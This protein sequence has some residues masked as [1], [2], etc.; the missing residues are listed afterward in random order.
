MDGIIPNLVKYILF[1]VNLAIF[2]LG[3]TVF[4]VGVW[5]FLDKPSFLV[6]FHEVD[7]GFIELYAT[8][9]YIIIVVSLLLIIVAF[10]GCCGSIKENRCMLGTY[11]VFILAA[12]ILVAVAVVFN[13]SRDL[14]TSL[15]TPL[16]DALKKYDDQSTED[17]PMFAYKEAWNEVQKEMKCCGV[18]NVTDWIDVKSFPKGMNKP[19]GCCM[20]EK[21]G[22]DISGNSSKVETC[23]KSRDSVKSTMYY[24]DG[25]Y[26]QI[27]KL[28]DANQ[29]VVLYVTIGI[30]G[31]LFLNLL[32]SFAMCTMVQRGHTYARIV[33]NDNAR[34]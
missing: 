31:L 30:L 27:I 4:G 21:N 25:C 20:W 5:V 2:V 33:G 28:I 29:N 10:F 26:T 3:C 1:V 16:E 13:Y 32:F 15:K 34:R 14:K 24:F 22:K 8:D 23:R 18:N 11:F 7:S 9:A 12:F 19:A 6:L 17:T